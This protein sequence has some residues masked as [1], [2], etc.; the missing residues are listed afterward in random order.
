M[1]SANP[2]ISVII[3]IYNGAK[4]IAEAVESIR[5]QDY[6]PME[7]VIIDDGSTDE[8]GQ[9]VAS[10]GNDIRYYYQRNTG[11]AAARNRGLAIARG[12]LIGFLDSDDLWP[13][14]K[15][16]VQIPRLATD[17][18]IDVVLGRIE[19]IRLPG[20]AEFDGH[21]D[22]DTFVD[23]HLGSGI[24]RKSVFDK[25]GVFDEMLSFSEDRDWF[26][27]AMEQGITI[28]VIEHTTLYYRLHSD[29]M[30]RDKNIIDFQF[31]KVLKKSLDRRR[32]QNNGLVWPLPKLSS[33]DETKIPVQA[34]A[35]LEGE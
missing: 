5:R 21:D 16:Q 33:F 4:F 18:N 35:D 30:T 31:I 26:L 27:R 28:A 22:A 15:L 19:C 10:L 1:T 9:I 12:E 7:I 17:P 32:R 8:T 24:F 34:Q 14:H 2:L 20:A 29:N 3:P 11:P 25:V 6:A 23:V 13:Q